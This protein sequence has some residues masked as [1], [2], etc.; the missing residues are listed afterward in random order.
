MNKKNKKKLKNQPKFEKNQI[1][2]NIKKRT[3]TNN[4]DINF[5]EGSEA[6]YSERYGWSLRKSK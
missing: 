3:L 1:E 6:Y 2:E 4:L 5:L